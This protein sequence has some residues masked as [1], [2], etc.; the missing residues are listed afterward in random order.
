MSRYTTEQIY[1]NAFNQISQI[2][3]VRFR[4]L[5]NF[6]PNLETAWQTTA[7][8]LKQAGFED[9]V[10]TKIL[11]SRKT[12]DPG[13]EASKLAKSGIHLITFSDTDYPP[14]LREIPN[15]PMVLYTLGSVLPLHNATIAV[16]GTRKITAYGRQVTESIVSDLARAGATIVSGL[17][18][19]IDSVAHEICVKMNCPTVA[20]LGCGI[21]GIYPA[22]NRLLSERIIGTGGMIVSELP[23]NAPPLKHHFPNRNRIISGLSLGTIVIEAAKESGALITAQHALEQNRE[24][25]AVPG[26]IY[27]EVSAGPNQLL[28]MGARLVTK[29]ADILEEL[30]LNDLITE[31][32]NRVLI[33]DNLEEQKILE[34]L[35]LEPQHFNELARIT[36]FSPGNLA[37][38]LTIMEM[39]GKVRN[40]GG[41]QYVKGR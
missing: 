22:S 3:S 17:A 16:V 34:Y 5:L 21:G 32:E 6:F 33:G 2:G 10:I 39:K 35:N 19:G 27:S 31:T 41:N 38:T 11:E 8:D 36:N 40:L 12:I 30:N 37:A 15:P 23:M 14:M 29:A 24:V 7:S 9:S 20:V 1:F 13:E 18:L 25:F 4:K 26:S 28:K